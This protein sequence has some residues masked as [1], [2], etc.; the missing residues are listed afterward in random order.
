MLPIRWFGIVVVLLL[1]G[2]GVIAGA[3]TSSPLCGVKCVFA[4]A[5]GLGLEID[6]ADV[7]RDEFVS[8][9]RGSS[10]DDLAR[11]SRAV[12]LTPRVVSRGHLWHLRRVGGPA[13]LHVRSSPEMRQPDHFVLLL[14]SH[15]D[16]LFDIYDPSHLPGIRTL[17]AV[18]VARVWSGTLISVSR[19]NRS[20]AWI[21]PMSAMVFVLCAV[22]VG[23]AASC[24][25][26]KQHRSLG[27]RVVAP[28]TGFCT[29]VLIVCLLAGSLTGYAGGVWSETA[30][31]LEELLAPLKIAGCELWEVV[32]AA[33]AHVESVNSGSDAGDTLN[34]VIL[35]DARSPEQ[36]HAGHIPGALLFSYFDLEGQRDP[37]WMHHTSRSRRIIVYCSDPNCGAA[38]RVARRL[39]RQGFHDVRVFHGGWREW[40]TALER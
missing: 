12:G 2:R 33:A 10:I 37:E 9:P 28:A 26:V 39:W 29:S 19:S 17:S 32:E 18:D 34:R 14:R 4:A 23:A 27:V 38:E 25:A 30:R 7:L 31:D 1:S 13:I 15:D 36:F 11:A 16:G 35:V 20:L 22:G 8:H 21:N 6:E 24:V 3:A 40:V 5:I